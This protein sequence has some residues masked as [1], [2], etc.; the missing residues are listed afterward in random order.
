M[1][2][3]KGVSDAVPGNDGKSLVLTMSKQTLKVFRFR[4]SLLST[5]PTNESKGRNENGGAEKRK[6]NMSQR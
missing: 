5:A 1:Q 3:Q 6:T 4:Q 2:F